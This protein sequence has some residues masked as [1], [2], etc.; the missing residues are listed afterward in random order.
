MTNPP[1]TTARIHLDLLHGLCTADLDKA[2]FTRRNDTRRTHRDAINERRDSA[3]FLIGKT[4]VKWSLTV[5]SQ[6]LLS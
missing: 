2:E 5:Y 4:Q 3:M 6:K 1:V